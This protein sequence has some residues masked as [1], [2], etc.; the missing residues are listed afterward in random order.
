M[1]G[2]SG[3]KFSTFLPLRSDSSR[4]NRRMATALTLRAKALREVGLTYKDQ[5]GVAWQ[6]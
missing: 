2:D 1:F 6:D 5:I 4:Y 3:L